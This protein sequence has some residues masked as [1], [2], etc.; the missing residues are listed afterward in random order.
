MTQPGERLIEEGLFRLGEDGRPRLI[1]SRCRACGTV[2]GSRRRVCLA[3]Y[4]RD[5][6]ERELE[7]E[8]T[9][10]SFTTVHQAGGG[11][12]LPVPYTIVQV[13]LPGGIV[14]TAPLVDCAPERVRVGLRVE[15]KAVRFDDPDGGKVVSWAFA[16]LSEKEEVAQ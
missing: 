12:L 13:S 11:V 8:G 6:E 2:F 1:G 14:V 9:V 3:C 4:S 15:T 16:P 10:H 5:L 7:R